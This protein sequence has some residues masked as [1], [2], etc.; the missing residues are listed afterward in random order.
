MEQQGSGCLYKAYRQWCQDTGEYPKKA[1]DF[2]TILESMGFNLKKT[3]KG[4]V[5]SGLSLDPKRLVGKTAD[6]EF[7]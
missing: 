4:N 7:A 3:M 1:S 6:T 2:K 5:W